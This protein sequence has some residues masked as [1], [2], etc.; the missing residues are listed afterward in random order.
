MVAPVPTPVPTPSPQQEDTRYRPSAHALSKSASLGVIDTFPD[1]DGECLCP[2]VSPHVPSV[3]P[4]CPP[5]VPPVSPL[6]LQPHRCPNLPHNDPKSMAPLPQLLIS[7]C[8]RAG[9]ASAL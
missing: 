4:P 3:S 8:S 5:H 6:V 9:C 2:P 7:A 1:W